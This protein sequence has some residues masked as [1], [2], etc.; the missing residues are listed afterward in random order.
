[1]PDVTNINSTVQP[2]LNWA[3]RLGASGL[4]VDFPGTGVLGIGRSAGA[5]TSVVQHARPRVR[6]KV[7]VFAQPYEG[8]VATQ[9]GQPTND[10]YMTSVTAVGED[11]SGP[12]RGRKP[13]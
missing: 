7:A 5:P 13:V 1:V 6:G 2:E 9:P 12:P 4:R 8:I 3:S 10:N 11:A